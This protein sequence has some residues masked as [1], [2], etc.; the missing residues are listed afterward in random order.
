MVTRRPLENSAVVV[1]SSN[2]LGSGGHAEQV[3]WRPPVFARARIG[4]A[5]R[6]P[7]VDVGLRVYARAEIGL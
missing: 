2:G 7:A 4:S 5:G 1:D 6:N 3:S